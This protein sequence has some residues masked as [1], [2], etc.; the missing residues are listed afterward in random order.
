MGGS[1]VKVS[2]IPLTVIA[3]E[4]VEFMEGIVGRNSVYACEIRT[5]RANW[6]S[7]GFGRVQFD[8]AEAAKEV[9][10]LSQLGLT[11]FQKDRLIACSTQKDIVPRPTYSVHGAELLVG[12]RVF[13]NDLCVLWSASD[14]VAE[15]ALERGKIDF[16]VSE[17]GVEYKLEVGFRDIVQSYACILKE[18]R[19]DA[20]LVQLQSAPKFFQ[21]VAV[22]KLSPEC[23]EDRYRFCKEDIEFQWVRTTDFSA[24]CSIGQST[25]FCIELPSTVGL[26]HIIESMPYHEEMEDEITLENGTSFFPFAHMVPSLSAPEDFNLPYQIYF[27]VSSLVHYGILSGPTLSREF[28]DLLQSDKTPA[29]HICLA[30][31]ELHKFKITCFEPEIWLRNQLNKLRNSEKQLKSAT[32]ST[33]RAI[34]KF[35]RALVTPS[36]VYFLGPELNV[37]NRVTRHFAEYIDDFLRV[38]FVDEDWNKLHSNALT[39]KPE[40][41][42][43][44]KPQRTKV[45]NRILSILKDGIVVGKKK[46]EFLAFSASQLRENSLWMFASNDKVTADSIRKWMGDF[47]NIRNVAKCA[48]RMGQSFSSSRQTSNVQEHEVLIIPD[49][50]VSTDGIKYCFSDGIGKISLP[51]AK[52]I[53]NKCGLSTIA[54]PSAFQ[55]RYGGYKG[56]VAIDPTSYHKLSLRPSMHKFNSKNTILD[57]LNWSRFLPAFLNREIITLLSTLGIPD[58]NFECLQKKTMVHLDQIMINSDMALDTLQIMSSGDDHKTLIEMLSGGYSPNTEPYL[59]MMLQAFREYQLLE[60]R[61]KCRIFV[62]KGRV[63]IGC[64]DETGTLNYGEVFIQVSKA[65]TKIY[66]DGLSASGFIDRDKTYILQGKV[67]VAKN[68]CLHPG[69]IRVLHAVNVPGLD[70]EY[71]VDCLVFPQKGERPHPY[72]CSGSDLDG[73]LYFVS[74]DELLIPPEQ[75]P[76]M[77][78]VGR[79]PIKLDHD[80]TIKEIQEY[81]VNYMLNDSLGVIANAHVVYADRDPLKARS[82]K[83]QLLARLHSKAVDFAKTGIPAEMP[84]SLIPKE[85]PDFMEKGNK[86]MYISSGILGKLYRAIKD[87]S[88]EI[89]CASMSTREDAHE[90]YDNDLKVEGFEEFIEDALMQ[91]SWYDSKLGALM[92]YYGVQSEAEI[93]SGNIIHFSKFFD[94]EKKRYGDIKEKVMVAVR[95]LRNEARAWF[96]ETCRVHRKDS[97]LACA[98]YHVTYHP[99]YWTEVHFISFPWIAYDVLLNVKKFNH[100]KK[101]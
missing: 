55:I 23:G 57:V 61:T 27:Q 33:D 92:E 67:V 20:I 31:A 8:N 86:P 38:S 54:P 28:F 44:A 51:L 21:K 101:G 16:F 98:W 69:D 48:A 46:F 95:A 42:F 34:M 72:E 43:L 10:R 90:A 82:Q 87:S 80:V 78:Y 85:F 2:S 12:C 49:I 94:K 4:L 73:D 5:E 37:S 59:S 24:F 52:Q 6:K 81:F 68:P 45:Y 70:H 58:Q 96:Q 50:E 76:P 64:L 91:K 89:P 32:I 13:H 74:W 25:S 83:C 97:A 84:L 9:C 39:S 15:F 88:K 99:D 35:H 19:T 7:R 1:T 75:D 30:L 3:K 29:L 40:Y 17:G 79:Q 14:V 26:A 93:L 60:L 36:K 66:D 53:A 65:N 11:L 63:L 41:G 18:R 47:D 56:V 22:Q 100:L 62:P 77:D 71:M